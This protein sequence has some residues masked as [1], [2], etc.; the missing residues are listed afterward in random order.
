LLALFKF[1]RSFRLSHKKFM[2][3]GTG[4]SKKDLLFFAFSAI[5]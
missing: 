4:M 5:I 1:A 2:Q 3:N